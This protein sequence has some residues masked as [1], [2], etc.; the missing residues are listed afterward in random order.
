MYGDMSG[1]VCIV[2]MYML[3]TCFC[4]KGNVYAADYEFKDKIISYAY[5]TYVRQELNDF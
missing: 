2:H 4:D 5:T 3:F 1:Y